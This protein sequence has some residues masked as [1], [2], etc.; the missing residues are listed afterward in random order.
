MRDD[1]VLLKKVHGHQVDEGLGNLEELGSVIVE[2]A[3]HV[4]VG[5]EVRETGPQD[6]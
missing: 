1:D 4:E 6:G 3:E 2:L 5:V